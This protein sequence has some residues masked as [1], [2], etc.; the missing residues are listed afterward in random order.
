MAADDIARDGQAEADAAGIPIS[1]V[2]ETNER[3]EGVFALLFRYAR[4]IL[5]RAGRQRRWPLS[6]RGVTAVPPVSCVRRWAAAAA[7]EP[8]LSAHAGRLLPHS[9]ITGRAIMA[10][11]SSQS[12]TSG[13]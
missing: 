10:A 8:P 13:K 7:G 6:S 12:I 9:P 11:A 5:A 2:F 3:P 1:R 4:S